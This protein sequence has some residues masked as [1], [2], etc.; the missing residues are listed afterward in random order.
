MNGMNT[1][2]PLLSI[3]IPTYNRAKI[4]EDV[5]NNYVSNKEFDDEVEIVI[6]DN[7]S[8]DETQS[9]C[10]KYAEKYH[11]IR[12]RRNDTNLRDINFVEVLNF[13]TGKY[14]KLMNDWTYY[15]ED[16]LRYVKDAIRENIN[17]KNL[18]FFSVHWLCTKWNDEE[19][20]KCNSLDEY[21]QVV[22]IIVTSNNLFGAWI[23]DWREIK[24]KIKYSDYK[25]QQDDWTYQ[26]MERKKKC[27]LYNKEKM[28][29]SNVP[30]GPRE[31]YN[32]FE[33]HLDN[34]Y[35]IMRPYIDKG[36][37]SYNTYKVDKRN[38]LY[39]YKHVFRNV[40]FP[41]KG[42]VFD[43]EGT[44]ALLWKYY[45]SDFLYAIYFFFIRL[46]FHYMEVLTKKLS[47]KLGLCH[48]YNAPK[49][50]GR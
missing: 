2:Q 48:K 23:E 35:K 18:I 44:T 5:L 19:I 50:P 28:S 7:A 6:S 36:L 30:L 21:V 1:K 29:V 33:V 20:I 27:I 45:K 43:T 10:E 25:L 11:N 12:Y 17:E 41:C 42:W 46:P 9:I 38:F 34:Y 16:G 24:D 49:N 22:S 32:W 8:T 31:G 26:L 39:Y 37:I 4:L 15:A 14:L 40:Y 47:R 13:A 3:C